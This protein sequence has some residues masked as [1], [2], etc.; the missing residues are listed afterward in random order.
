MAVQESFNRMYYPICQELGAWQE[1]PR[2]RACG[3][4]RTYAVF[5]EDYSARMIHKVLPAVVLAVVAARSQAPR[6]SWGRGP[7]CPASGLSAASE[8][9]FAHLEDACALMGE[10]T[11]PQMYMKILLSRVSERNDDTTSRAAHLE[12]LG[13]LLGGARARGDF[14]PH[15][16]SLLDAMGDATLVRTRAPYLRFAAMECLER[17]AHCVAAPTAPDAVPRWEKD[18]EEA[19]KDRA[20]RL[21][22][23]KQAAK[24][25]EDRRKV[26]LAEIDA[27]PD[28]DDDEEEEEEEVKDAGARR[29]GTTKTAKRAEV[30]RDPNPYVLDADDSWLDMELYNARSLHTDADGDGMLRDLDAKHAGRLARM[31]LFLAAS[32]T[33]DDTATTNRE[34]TTMTA[35]TTATTVIHP[36]ESVDEA[37][38]R[39]RDATWDVLTEG[40]ARRIGQAEAEPA[41]GLALYGATSA[42]TVSARSGSG[43]GSSFGS[44]EMSTDLRVGVSAFEMAVQLVGGRGAGPTAALLARQL[45][46]LRS[47]PATAKG[48]NTMT[49]TTTT[50]TDAAIAGAADAA[51]TTTTTSSSNSSMEVEVR[52]A[53]LGA[54]VVV[55][56]L[57]GTADE[58]DE[59]V[60]AAWREVVGPLLPMVVTG[61]PVGEMAKLA[62]EIGAYAGKGGDGGARGGVRAELV[63]LVEEMEREREGGGVGGRVEFARAIVESV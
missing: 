19:E 51:A 24:E 10:A 55:G 7:L 50:T 46:G 39:L 61:L 13:W 17:L 23:R 27:L 29:R 60:E 53:R 8:T 59:E 44:L 15:V 36:A 42:G 4:L 11:E 14:V 16:P 56:V 48:T 40:L 58:E 12:V 22:Q 6:G 18:P 31:T 3:L 21:I 32:R 54:R 47:L 34:T 35:T 57:R 26:R 1:G 28:D 30:E 33:D 41:L 52:K 20:R 49:T 2:V 25:F 37:C 62:T 43:S 5:L 63:R 45:L 9:S 38:A